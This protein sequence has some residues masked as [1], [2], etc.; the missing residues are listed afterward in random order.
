LAAVARIATGIE[1]QAAKGH[2]GLLELTDDLARAVDGSRDVLARRPW[3]EPTLPWQAE[4]AS[5]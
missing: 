4:T 5:A 2:L 1:A 3:L